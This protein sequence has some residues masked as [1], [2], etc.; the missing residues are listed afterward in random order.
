MKPRPAPPMAGLGQGVDDPARNEAARKRF[1]TQAREWLPHRPRALFE[2]N[3]TP[4]TAWTLASVMNALQHWKECP[5][6]AGIRDAAALAKL[7]AETNRRNGRAL[8]ARV[9]ELEMRA[10]DLMERMRAESARVPSC[11]R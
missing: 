11:R 2:K 4:A 9:P 1:R 5:D 7:P 3:L 10:N 6:L 8:W